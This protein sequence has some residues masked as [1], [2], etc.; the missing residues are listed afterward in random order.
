MRELFNKGGGHG[1]TSSMEE[2]YQLI[3]AITRSSQRHCEKIA[4]HNFGYLFEDLARDRGSRLPESPETIAAL[5]TL[6][7]GMA[8]PQPQAGPDS[9]IPAGYTYLGQF[10]DHDITRDAQAKHLRE[11]ISESMFDPVLPDEARHLVKNLRSATLELDSV[12]GGGPNDDSDLYESD[13]VLLKLGRN[14]PDTLGTPDHIDTACSDRDI[15]RQADGTPI[16]GDGRNDEN[17]LLSQTHHA[18]KVFHNKIARQ[19]SGNSAS[20]FAAAQKKVIQH[21]QWIV[22]HDYLPRI[23]NRTAHRN[24]LHDT[25][26]SVS[27][28]HLTLPTTPYV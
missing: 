24:A 7:S 3:Q 19:L 13:K 5:K 28:T 12:Y 16:I 14:R 26:Y 21:Y 1:T 15:L 8:D 2:M 20:R 10:I 23:V 27:Y 18:F 6:G 11:L 25:R 17:L 22:L 9:D 4:M